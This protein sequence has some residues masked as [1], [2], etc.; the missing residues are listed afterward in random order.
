MRKGKLITGMLSGYRIMDLVDES[1]EMR[2]IYYLERNANKIKNGEMFRT[3]ICGTA[4]TIMKDS[5]IQYQMM[6]TLGRHVGEYIER[7][8]GKGALLNVTTPDAEQCE[9]V[10]GGSGIARKR[11]K[12][13]EE[14]E[15]LHQRLEDEKSFEQILDEDAYDIDILDDD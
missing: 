3:Y 10:A 5:S 4:C 6:S 12:L 1:L 8:A 7:I 15:L 2:S 9:P 13:A 14:K 11:L